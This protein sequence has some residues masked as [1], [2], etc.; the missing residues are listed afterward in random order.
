MFIKEYIIGF[1]SNYLVYVIIILL[2]LVLISLII[3]KPYSISDNID[4]SSN[5]VVDNIEENN[6]SDVIIDIKGAVKNPGVYKVD[7]RTIVNDVIREA[8]GLLKNAT[9]INLNL[10]M[11]VTDRMVIYVATKSELTKVKSDSSNNVLVEVNNNNNNDVVVKNDALVNNKD[12]IGIEVTKNDNKEIKD[13]K[14]IKED[15]GVNNKAISINTA[16]LEE[17]ITLPSIGEAKA[18][19]I[20]EYRETN[21]LFKS[22]EDIKNVSGI[23]DSLFEK[24]KDYITI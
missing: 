12:S 1:L 17:L 16:T 14:D 2:E 8:G 15:S 22:I 21:G 23:G 20:I 5:I 19:K 9:T 6:I 13:N 11:Q 3:I 18:L 7:S 10:G 24:I 4:N